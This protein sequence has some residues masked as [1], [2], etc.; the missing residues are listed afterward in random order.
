MFI[1]SSPRRNCQRGRDPPRKLIPPKWFARLPA[2]R[3]FGRWKH[4]SRA[5]VVAVV[6]SMV[7]SMV[8]PM[9]AAVVAVMMMVEYSAPKT[10][11]NARS[12]TVIVAGA[13]FIAGPDPAIPVPSSLT[14]QMHL[15]GQLMCNR[16][17]QSPIC[18]HRVCTRADERSRAGECRHSGC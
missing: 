1:Y 2:A 9:M 6:A 7:A 13:R 15:F 4:S 8:A 5:L 11:V 10:E 18:R 3:S 12:A 14:Y 16:S 17:A